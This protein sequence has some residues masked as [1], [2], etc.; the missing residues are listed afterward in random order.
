MYVKLR[1]ALKDF[2]KEHNLTLNDVLEVMDEDPEGIISSLQKRTGISK[3]ELKKLLTLYGPKKLNAAILTLQI[4][5]LNNPSGIY[6]GK[7]IVPK[8]EEI[9]SEGERVSI[10]GLKKIILEIET[11]ITRK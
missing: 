2:L 11:R 5:Y 8:R 1:D 7:I 10:N 3:S 4:F 6:K 9:I